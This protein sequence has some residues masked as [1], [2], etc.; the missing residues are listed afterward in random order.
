MEI[1]FTQ[2]MLP[3]GRRKPITIERP[4]PIVRKA[5]ELISK[6]YEFHIE[7]LTTGE[8]HMTISDGEDDVACELCQNGPD[9]PVHVDKMITEFQPTATKLVD[10][11]EDFDWLDDD[12]GSKLAEFKAKMARDGFVMVPDDHPVGVEG[13]D[14]CFYGPLAYYR[15]R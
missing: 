7:T 12:D 6:G 5:L 2:F 10:T 13:G 3:D 15:K 8:I 9:V 4:E 1:P 14:Y 11:S